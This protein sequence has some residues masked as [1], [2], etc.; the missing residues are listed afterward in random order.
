MAHDLYYKREPIAPR[1]SPAL[2]PLMQDAVKAMK[3]A[4]KRITKQGSASKAKA[5]RETGIRVFKNQVF[6]CCRRIHANFFNEFI[7]LLFLLV[8]LFCSLSVLAS[9]FFF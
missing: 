9:S 1:P 5:D 6:L 4:Q 7:A 8:F 2:E 3:K